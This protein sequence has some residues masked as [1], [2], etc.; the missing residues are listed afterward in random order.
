VFDLSGEGLQRAPTPFAFSYLAERAGQFAY[1]SFLV[2]M[3]PVS[4]IAPQVPAVALSRL[5]DCESPSSFDPR[6]IGIKQPF[7]Y[8]ELIL[9]FSLI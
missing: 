7:I 9:N 3:S 1:R 4:P 5:G 8:D 2:L 6:L